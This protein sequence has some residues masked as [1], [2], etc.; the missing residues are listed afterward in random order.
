MSGSISRFTTVTI[1]AL[2]T[3]DLGVAIAS[4]KPLVL[5]EDASQD[6]QAVRKSQLDKVKTDLTLAI[7]T[8]AG[9]DTALDTI[10]EMKAFVDSVKSTGAAD[11]LTAITGETTARGTAIAAASTAAA[12]ALSSVDT[13]VRLL[14]TNEAATRGADD[15]VLSDRLFHNVNLGLSASIYADASEPLPMPISV[16]NVTAHDGWYYKN[17]GPSSTIKKINWYFAAP[18]GS[19]GAATAASLEELDI[20]LRLVNNVSKPFITVYTALQTSGNASSWYHAKYTYIAKQTVTPNTNYL[21]RALISGSSAVGSLTGFT[22]L[23][24]ELD[25]FSSTPS[26]PLLPTDNIL[27]IAVGTDS[28]SAAGNVECVIHS[29][30]V[31]SSNGNV[32]YQLSNADVQSKYIAKQVSQLFVSMH[33]PDPMA[34]Y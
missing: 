4:G 19:S 26:N 18:V 31:F 23:D 11:L 5:G 28:G 16:K 17:P 29:L 32:A 10:T 13:A 27:F 34:L 24:L 30:N 6:N 20:P 15:K 25:T 9:T 3:T 8:I 14:I 7:E 2:T 21:F 12:S 22:A 1:G 33:Q